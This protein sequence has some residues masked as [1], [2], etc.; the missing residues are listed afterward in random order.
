MIIDVT[1]P[2][3]FA[4]YAISASEVNGSWLVKRDEGNKTKP[5][6]KPLA[7]YLLLKAQSPEAGWILN[8]AKQIPELSLAFGISRRTFF[9]YLDKLEEIGLAER[10][11]SRLRLAGWKDAGRKLNINTDTKT[12]IQYTLYGKF[13][14]HLWFA[15]L[16]IEC[17][18]ELQAAT[19]WRKLNK[20]STTRHLLLS[21]L[22]KRG[23]KYEDRDDRDK[24]IAALFMLYMRDFATG[25]EVHDLLIEYRSD[26][27]R[28]LKAIAWSWNVS[29]S[30]VSYY[31]KQMSAEKIINVS[32]VAV[33]SNWSHD[34]RDCHKNKHCHVIWD[35][36]VKERVSFNRT[37]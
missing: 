8:Y 36:A 22:C 17:N 20:N 28:T 24:F 15:A 2:T 32:K 14:L 37:T 26:I 11:G 18:Q 19:L 4:V 7:F 27:N 23:Y 29:P 35:A 1:I 16:E 12:T 31:K 3:E 25:T 9:N 13:T 21:A 6:L 34:T 30:L 33:M 10:Q 5:I